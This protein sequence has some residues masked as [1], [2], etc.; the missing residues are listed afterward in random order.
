MDWLIA[1]SGREDTLTSRYLTFHERHARLPPFAVN[2][3]GQSSVEIKRPMSHRPKA[4]ESEAFHRDTSRGKPTNKPRLS[5]YIEQDA[6][7][8]VDVFNSYFRDPPLSYPTDPLW[9]TGPQ[10]EFAIYVISFYA[11]SHPTGDYFC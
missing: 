10:H 1:N 8:S 6:I 11:A 2:T 7:Y 5:L 9:F 4:R 3:Q